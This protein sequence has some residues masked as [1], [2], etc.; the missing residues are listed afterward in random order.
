[1]LK[2]NK[3]CKC[4]KLIWSCSIICPKCRVKQFSKK[5][6]PSWKGGLPHCKICNKLLSNYDG[7]LCKKCNLTKNN[8]MF[9]KST[10]N[11]VKE[12][13]KNWKFTKMQKKKLSLARLKF[14]HHLSKKDK[15]KLYKNRSKS[16]LKIK[17]NNHH[18]DLNPNN[19]E[20]SNKI[21]LP[22][23]IHLKLHIQAYR[24]LVETNLLKKYLNWFDKKYYPILKRLEIK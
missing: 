6:H 11:K 19:N 1:M 16:A 10:I 2:K 20:K 14:L 9:K 13:R 24:F 5:N 23:R 4:G 15:Q 12:A 17:Y 3:H 7:I 21:K 18:L 22:K 8:P